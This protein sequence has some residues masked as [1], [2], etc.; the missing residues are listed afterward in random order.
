M[1]ISYDDWKKQYEGMTTE[2]QKNYASMVKG[3]ATAEEYANRYIQERGLGNTNSN[4]STNQNYTVNNTQWTNTPTATTNTSNSNNQNGST[5]DF[6]N[7]NSETRYVTDEDRRRSQEAYKKTMELYWNQNGSPLSDWRNWDGNT[8]WK[9]VFDADEYLDQSKFWKSDWTGIQVKE[10]TAAQTGRPDYTAEDTNRLNEMI[11]N[12]NEYRNTNPSFFNDRDTFNRVFEYNQRES[13]AQRDLLDSYWKKAQDYKKASSYNNSSSFSTDLDNWNISES[14]FEAL[15]QYN[16]DVYIKWQQDM[17]NKLNSAIANLA[18]P[19]SIDDMTTALNKIIEKFNLQAGD[20]YDVIWWWEDMMQRTWA[21]DSMKEAQ[22]Q[23]TDADATIAKINSI[24]K[25][26][27]NSTSNLSSARMNKAL[28]PYISLLSNQLASGQHWQSL[29][30]TQLWTANNYANTIQMQGQEDTRAF[31]DKLNALKF[32]MT[33]DSY[34]TPEQQQQLLLQT[35][36]IRNDMSLL[37]QSKL[38]DLSLYNQYAT[39]K[40][41]NQLEYELQDLN[42]SD[43]A[44]LRANLSRVLDQYYSQYWDIIQRPKQQVI[45]DVIAQAEA[46]WISV[47]EALR[48]NFIEPLQSKPEY[49]K[50]VSDAYWMNAKNEYI[51]IW[52]SW[53]VLTTNPDGSFSVSYLWWGSAWVG[54]AGS[55]WSNWVYNFSEWEVRTWDTIWNDINS[56][57][58]ILQSDD[59]LRV[60]TYT[61][62]NWYTYNVYPDRETWIQ[63]TVNLLKKWYYW[64]TLADAAQKWIWQ[65]KDISTAKSVITKLWLSLDEKLGDNNVRKFI[66]AMWTWEWTLKWWQSLEDWAKWGKDLSWYKTT[67]EVSWV[68][69]DP[70]SWVSWY[71][72]NWTEINAGWWITSLESTYAQDKWRSDWDR[73]AVLNWYWITIKDFNEQRKKYA[74]HMMA[75]ELQSTLQDS[76]DRINALIEWEDKENSWI[77]DYHQWWLDRMSVDTEGEKSWV[78]NLINPFWSYTDATKWKSLFD[79]LKNNETLN[80]FLNLKQ[81]W[82]TFWA[83]QQAEWDMI[84]SS[85]SELKWEQP[86]E[87]FQD[88]LKKVK[89]RLEKQMMEIDPSYSPDGWISADYLEQ[90][91]L[92]LNQTWA[93]Y[94]NMTLTWMID[95]VAW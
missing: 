95:Y 74:E 69:S 21:W 76:L 23:F 13:Q 40:L 9:F 31:N 51:K 52:D 20:P 1:A 89:E 90:K 2:Q 92:K 6:S 3:N 7:N 67:E 94:N 72:K 22:K 14:E 30:Q 91:W 87:V 68:T 54:S 47:A 86:K 66:E 28:E 5:Y 85:V 53:A 78:D 50:S 34:R 12:L 35:E 46:E 25:S 45:D 70:Y 11:H 32:A 42:V 33:A 8:Y 37:N 81:N 26:Y 17:Q 38:N 56:I 19:F 4:G 41:E 15:K 29:Y 43:P 65:W 83:M 77:W 84:A 27:S 62:K 48:K 75:T 24:Q 10:G 61:S 58:H 63:A 16:Q 18:N 60:W 71:T 79:Y 93:W 82:A 57:W 73:D 44:Q 49:K 88:N 55:V 80:K 64:K 59:W 36:Q 39:A